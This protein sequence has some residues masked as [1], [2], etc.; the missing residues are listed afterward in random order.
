PPPP[1]YGPQKLDGDSTCTE[2]GNT[3]T[4]SLSGTTATLT[5]FT[6]TGTT[7]K[8]PKTVEKDDISYTVT[9]IGES[10]FTPSEHRPNKALQSV[11]LPDSIRTIEAGAF[12]GCH[13]LQNITLR[14]GLTE[15]KDNAFLGADLETIDWPKSLTTVGYGAFH[16]MDSSYKP[17]PI[18]TITYHGTKAQWDEMASAQHFATTN[19][20]LVAK[21]TEDAKGVDLHCAHTVTFNVNGHGTDPDNQVVDKQEVQYEG[22]AK[23]PSDPTT[24]G[25]TFKGWYTEPEGGEPFDFTAEITEDKTAYAHWEEKKPENP[26]QPKPPQKPDDNKADTDKPNKPNDPTTPEQPGTPEKPN[27]PTPP[28]APTVEEDDTAAIGYAAAA[29]TAAFVGWGAYRIGSEVYLKYLLP[30]DVLLP[31]NRIQLAELLW[32]DAGRPAPADAAA[33]TDVDDTDAR[34]AARWAVENGLL[35]LPDTEKPEEFA[36][37]RSVSYAKSARAWNKAQ[38]LKEAAAAR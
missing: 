18:K 7:A 22:C 1:Y 36:P 37:Y 25:F 14:E 10:A 8:V 17:K 30:K 31:Q 4:Y 21:D 33:Y 3:Y 6:G 15:V 32:E 26:E 19:P 12:F 16:M 35:T 28:E 5:S 24:D 34:Q 29:V 9:T 27:E 38:Q 11:N 23:K 20:Q 13:S 2:D